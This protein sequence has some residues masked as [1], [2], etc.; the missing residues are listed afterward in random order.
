MADYRRHLVKSSYRWQG[1]GKFSGDACDDGQLENSAE[2]NS[3]IFDFP[4]CDLGCLGGSNH[5][6]TY[7]KWKHEERRAGELDHNGA[8]A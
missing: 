7:C 4:A 3:I 8:I 2:K 5:D 1:I 6:C